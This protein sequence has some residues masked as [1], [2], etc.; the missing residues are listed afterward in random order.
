AGAMMNVAVLLSGGGSNLQ[1]LIDAHD[2]G[3]LAAEIAVVLSDRAEAYGL[4][5]AIQRGI[6]S[7]FVPLPRGPDQ[8]SRATTRAAWEQRLIAVLAA[9]EPDLVVLTGFM[10]VLSPAF[11]AHFPDRVINQHPA[12]LPTGGGATVVTS[13]GLT[14]PALRGAHVVPDALRQGLP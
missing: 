13:S 1:A 6:P 7:A 5:R 14:I 11:L 8:A 10:R 3:A 2:A 12:L 4:Q 9:F